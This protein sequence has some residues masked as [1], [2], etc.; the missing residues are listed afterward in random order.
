LFKEQGNY[1]ICLVKLAMIKAITFDLDGVYFINGKQNFYKELANFGVAESEA[2]RVFAQSDEMNELYKTGK[3]SDEEFWSWA[4]QGWKLDIPAEQIIDLM[5]KSYEIDEGVVE[6]VRKIRK[7][8]YKTLICSNNFPARINGLNKRFVFLKDFDAYVFS[9]EVGVTKPDQKIF[10]VLIAKSGCRPEEI[11]YSDDH[12]EKMVGAI[13]L[14][15]KTF[16]YQNL[17]QFLKEIGTLGVKW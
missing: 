8:G 15:I 16:T 1:S 2:K 6:I 3:W 14:G 17:E 10:E 12:E 7:A 5:I 13:N 9:Y 11:I 4:K